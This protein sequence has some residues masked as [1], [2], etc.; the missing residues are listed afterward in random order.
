VTRARASGKR[1]EAYDRPEGGERVDG[2]PEIDGRQRNTVKKG[3]RESMTT[4][5]LEIPAPERVPAELL[6][7]HSTPAE[8]WQL[9]NPQPILRVA[10]M[11]PYR[12][13]RREFLIGAAGLL[14]LPAGCGGGGEGSG[15]GTS[16]ETRTVEHALGT[17]EVPVS[18]ERIVTHDTF[19]I[20]TLISLGV[21]PVGVRDQA[22]IARYLAREVEGIESVGVD[23]N[24]EAVAALEPDLILTTEG[25]ETNEEL[26][27]IAPTVA[28]AFESSGDWK[29]IHL[30]FSEALGMEEE[31]R[32]VL[33]EYEARAREIGA[34]F[35]DSPPEVTIMRA[36]EEFGLS[37]YLPDSFPGTVVKDAGLARPEGQRGEGFT[38]EISLELV[39]EAEADAV[40]VWAFEDSPRESE[41]VVRDLREDPLFGRLNVARRGDVYVGGDYWI[42]SGVL[43]ANLILDDIENALLG[44]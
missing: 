24:L 7:R 18:P 26:S 23:P 17:T 10:G 5:K 11:S 35:G 19:A 12:P 37:F 21:E 6:L 34:S 29:E 9:V 41:D 2:A 14:L 30:K 38:K 33:D 1:F 3:S 42:G 13:T 22:T 25:Y 43:A 4:K 28:A 44:A 27:R 36:S 20:D 32:R 8:S 39:G 40:F 15:E 16:G 31:G